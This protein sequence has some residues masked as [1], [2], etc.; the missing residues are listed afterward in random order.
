MIESLEPRQLLATFDPAQF[1]PA[2]PVQEGG[3]LTINNA[4][5]VQINAVYN[6][7]DTVRAGEVQ[8]IDRSVRTSTVFTGIDTLIVNG[9]RAYDIISGN[10]DGI[11]AIV[12]GGSGH[13]A[14]TFSNN[15]G[16]DVVLHGGN[17]NDSIFANNNGA[18]T[19]T[20]F[21][22]RGRDSFHGNA[23]FVP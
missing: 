23:V 17:G 3:T 10:V 15:G 21:G 18:G 1:G 7:D 14:I 20:A 5:D 16:G 19:L 6:D 9:T 12:N 8:L 2:Q 13:D 22:D 4:H 11:D